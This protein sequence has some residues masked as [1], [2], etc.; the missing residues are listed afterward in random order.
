MRWSNVPIPEP[1]LVGLV[2]GAILQVLFPLRLFQLPWIG[3]AM[4]LPLFLSGAGLCAWSVLEA[5]EMNIASPNRLLTS[6]PYALSRNPMYVGWTLIY[7]G[8]TLAVNS[9]WILGLLP[10]VILYIHFVETRKEEQRLAEQFGDD[11]HNYRR[12]V[13]R[14]L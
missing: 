9:V 10:L 14:Y 3:L 11:Y 12:Q 5:K 7:I 8:I 1:H 6:G 2:M 13:R 4:G